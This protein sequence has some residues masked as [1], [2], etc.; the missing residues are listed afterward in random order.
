MLFKKGI[1]T[2]EIVY[3]TS[4]SESLVSEYIGIIKEQLPD[5]Y[6]AYMLNLVTNGSIVNTY[7]CII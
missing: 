5:F 2:S 6:K 7:F 1:D 3:L 4:M